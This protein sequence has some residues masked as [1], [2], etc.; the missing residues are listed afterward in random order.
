MAKELHQARRIHLGIGVQSFGNSTTIVAKPKR[1]E[2]F[3]LESG[4]LVIHHEF[5]LRILV[6]FSNI[7]AVDFEFASKY[8]IEDSDDK[9]TEA[10]SKPKPGYTKPTK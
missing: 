7:K 3:M 2:L 1:I 6:P 5:K 8:G 10:D 4:V 9:P